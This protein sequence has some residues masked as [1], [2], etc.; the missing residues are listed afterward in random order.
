MSPVKE[1]Q[2][3]VD[4]K[5]PLGNW[6]RGMSWYATLFVSERKLAGEASTHYTRWPS[7]P[8]VMEK[9]S[10]AIP[11][12]KLIYLVRNPLAR[13]RSHYVM[14]CRYGRFEGSFEDYC[15]QRKEVFDSSCYGT[16]IANCLRFFPAEQILVVESE[17]LDRNRLLTLAQ[18]FAF[19][20]AEATFV[21]ESYLKSHNET[22]DAPYPSAFGFKIMRSLP[23]RILPHLM[24][25][26][27]WP[28]VRNRILRPFSTDLPG[29][30]LSDTAGCEIK[31]RLREE[32]VLLRKLTGKSLRSLNVK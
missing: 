14:S 32:M 26:Q 13:L 31:A 29:T 6:S 1:P 15:V 3:F 18:I 19:L 20:G 21:S 8:G 22:S 7:F 17:E 12:A 9:M 16:Q 24:T 4:E 27:A 30:E 10:A 25:K 11:A 28:K 5:P 2:F 23:M